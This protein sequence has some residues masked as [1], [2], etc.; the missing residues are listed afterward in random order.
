MTRDQEI[1]S[2]ILLSL[3]AARPV[4][5]SAALLRRQ[6]HKEGLDYTE[7][8]MAREAAFLVGQGFATE[9]VNPVTGQVVFAITSAGILQHERFGK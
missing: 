1:R 7:T 5:M 4:G 8:E 3:Y 9:T 2:D 6:A